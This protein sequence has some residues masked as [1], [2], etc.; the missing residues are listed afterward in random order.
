MAPSALTDDVTI[1]EPS[2]EERVIFVSVE[3]IHYKTKCVW[4]M[5]VVLPHYCRITCASIGGGGAGGLQ[6]L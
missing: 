2:G 6:S 3:Y 5:I 1:E 4:S